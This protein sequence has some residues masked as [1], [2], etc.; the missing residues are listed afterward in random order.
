MEDKQ[1]PYSLVLALFDRISFSDFENQDEATEIKDEGVTV[2][3]STKY[4]RTY[5]AV[6]PGFQLVLEGGQEIYNGGLLQSYATMTISA[7]L[8]P[9][10]GQEGQVSKDRLILSAT[11]V[12]GPKQTGFRLQRV[13]PAISQVEFG[14]DD[15]DCRNQAIEQF[16]GSWARC[17]MT[18][19]QK[20]E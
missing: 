1:H 20:S 14:K 13:I 5:T 7:T 8:L 9:K 4:R 19:E 2:G 3:T 15:A 10:E 6:N 16:F 11:F 12:A 17:L 18:S